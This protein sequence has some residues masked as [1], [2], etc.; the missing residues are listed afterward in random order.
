MIGHR[1]P[2]LSSIPGGV[3]DFSLIWQ[4]PDWF[5]VPPSLL[6][7]GYQ[8]AFSLGESDR[9]MN[10]S[11]HLHLVCSLGMYGIVP[12]VFRAW[13]FINQKDSCTY[14]TFT[15]SAWKFC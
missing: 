5:W 12:Y 2:N 7:G 13:Y 9:G 11:T 10:L 8:G 15:F 1:L 4:C 3:R 14:F 6:R